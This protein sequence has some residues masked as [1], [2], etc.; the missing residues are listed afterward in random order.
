MT[1]IPDIDLFALRLNTKI[2]CFVSWHPEPGAM[3]VDAFSIS[4]ANLKCYAFPP[5]SL[6]T[7]VLAKIRNDKAL[8]LLIAPVWTTQ[9]WYSLLLQLEVEQPISLPLKDNLLTLPHSQ[10]LHPLK[11]SL[12]L[13][14]WMLSRDRL[15]TEAFL[16]MQS[17]SSVHLGPLGLIN[18]TTQPG[19]N[20][21]AGASKGKLVYFRHLSIK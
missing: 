3:A 7:Q 13:A 15:Q 9:N 4:W 16:M 12:H 19:R 8:V 6:L 1:F 2:D 17:Q 11:D 21:V 10:E 14:A 18:S 20:G 5:F